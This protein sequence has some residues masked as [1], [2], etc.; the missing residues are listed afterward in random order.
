MRAPQPTGLSTHP[1]PPA[2]SGST[3]PA[4]AQG[5]SAHCSEARELPCQGTVGMPAG[6]GSWHRVPAG[7]AFR[8]RPGQ[9]ALAAAHTVSRRQGQ[10][11]A[12]VR[13]APS[14]PSDSGRPH[15]AGPSAAPR[16]PGA[17]STFWEASQ[18]RRR[19]PHG[20]SRSHRGR[21]SRWRGERKGGEPILSQDPVSQAST[22]R[23]PGRGPLTALPWRGAVATPRTGLRWDLC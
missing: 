15:P 22:P 17:S 11:P 4:R 5:G 23:R 18:R 20:E 14:T 19:K 7:Q 21:D 9:P 13:A 2:R 10:L 3:G 8:S 6:T 16:R 12:W 1:Q